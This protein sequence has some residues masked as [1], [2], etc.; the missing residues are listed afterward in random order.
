[1]VIS[2]RFSIGKR[3]CSNN[4]FHFFYCPL[5]KSSKEDFVFFWW[6]GKKWYVALRKKK[7]FMK[8][9]TMELIHILKRVK[10]GRTLRQAAIDYFC[11]WSMSPQYLYKNEDRLLSVVL[12]FFYD[13]VETVD[14]PVFVWKE[15]FDR[16]TKKNFYQEDFTDTDILLSIMEMSQVLRNKKYV[17]GFSSYMSELIKKQN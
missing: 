3:K 17:N 6:F 10:N 2:K 15:Y 1:M 8:K 4:T 16:K 9:D 12:Q 7:R 14:N 11:E 13:Y 5:L